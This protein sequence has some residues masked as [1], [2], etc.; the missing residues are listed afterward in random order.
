MQLYNVE[1]NE[2][3]HF[4]LENCQWITLLEEKRIIN[5]PARVLFRTL[6]HLPRVRGRGRE[7]VLTGRGKKSPLGALSVGL[8]AYGNIIKEESCSQSGQ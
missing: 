2:H 1:I 4:D 3:F 5:K 8:K 7:E 6:F